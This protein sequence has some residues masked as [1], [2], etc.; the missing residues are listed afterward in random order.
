MGIRLHKVA[1]SAV[2]VIALLLSFAPR[3]SATEPLPTE[4]I[5]P[6]QALTE[7]VAPTPAPTEPP[8]TVPEETE[9]AGYTVDTSSAIY[10]LCA[11][12]A[13]TIQA[14]QIMV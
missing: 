12:M 14:R 7:T 11:Q 9:P 1:F 5:A 8:E 6:T 10:N 4:T 3:I 2:F 13:E